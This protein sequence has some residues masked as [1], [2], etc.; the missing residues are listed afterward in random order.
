MTTI[1]LP[2]EIEGPLAEAARKRGTTPE[3]L[4]LESLQKLF[5]TAAP[6][7]ESSTVE[8]QD[9]WERRPLG[10]AKDCGVSLADSATRRES[11]YD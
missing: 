8:P 6:S 5:G 7:T 1:T 10:L 2:P 3:R 11:L 4:A 9:D